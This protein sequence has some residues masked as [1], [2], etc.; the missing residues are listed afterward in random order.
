MSLAVSNTAVPFAL[1]LRAI[2]FVHD[3][4]AVRWLPLTPE[5]QAT[6]QLATGTTNDTLDA[7]ETHFEDFHL[8]SVAQADEVVAGCC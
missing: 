4:T 7:I 8:G 3:S 1:A 2:G 5:G 6:T